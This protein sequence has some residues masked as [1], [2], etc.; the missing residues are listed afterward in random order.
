MT[1]LSLRVSR[2]LAVMLLGCAPLSALAA[3]TGCLYGVTDAKATMVDM[4]HLYE[5]ADTVV[6]GKVAGTPAGDGLTLQVTSTEKGTPAKEITLR[7]QQAVNTEMNGFSLPEGS[8]VLVFL[9]APV[10]GIY[11]SVEDYNSPCNI[12]RFVRDGKV[13]MIEHD[14]HNP[15]IEVPVSELK[16]Y[17][18]KGHQT[19]NYN[20]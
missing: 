10:G 1:Q 16:A 17:L 4:S 15:G 6:T 3:P 18:E 8:E 19:L 12:T 11:D 14:D 20:Y 2:F 9:K 13:I 5:A 7:S